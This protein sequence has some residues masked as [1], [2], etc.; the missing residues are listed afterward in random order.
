MKKLITLCVVVLF[1]FGAKAQLN[2]WYVGG[3]IGFSS[4][5]EDYGNNTKTTSWAFGPE[6]GVGIGENWSVGL[7]LG[8]NG[9]NVSDDN[10]DVSSTF[11]FVPD[12]YGRRWWTLAD[13]LKLFAGLDLTFGSGNSTQYNVGQQGV[14]VVTD[15][16]SFGVN[17][18]SG[19]A[20]SLADR[21]TL[22]FKLAG[23]GFDSSTRADNT[24][25]TFWLLGDG[26]V[27]NGNFLFVGIYWTFLPGGGNK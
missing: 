18:N 15:V 1:A 5:S 7:V 20:Y 25:T 12:I 24:D 3:I 2:N 21:W 23:V 8:L 13:R 19:I 22:L 6:V 16:S 14:D 10:G 27:T 17:L 11:M 4:N 9:M 26:N